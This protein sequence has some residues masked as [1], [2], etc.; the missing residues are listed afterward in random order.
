LKIQ[1][2]RNLQRIS[3]IGG[4]REFDGELGLETFKSKIERYVLA[5]ETAFTAHKWRQ[6]GE[7][8][9]LRGQTLLEWGRA[10]I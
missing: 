10:A 2:S 1:N 7:S 3:N 4:R 6:M 5:D 8:G 9:N